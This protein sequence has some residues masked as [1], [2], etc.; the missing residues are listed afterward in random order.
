MLGCVMELLSPFT[1]M[2]SYLERG[3]RRVCLLAAVTAGHPPAALLLAGLSYNRRNVP[4]A[5]ESK[6]CLITQVCHHP[7]VSAAHAENAHFQYSTVSAPTTRF[8]GNS[9]EIFPNSRN[10]LL[11]KRSG[12]VYNHISPKAKANNIIIGRTWVDAFGD[13]HVNN[14]SNGVRC[15]LDFK[16]CG[17][18]SSNRYN[19]TGKADEHER[20]ARID[21]AVVPCSGVLAA[22]EA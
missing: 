18:F 20:A 17:W 19:F 1:P 14:A 9:L 3:F 11:L 15:L 16:P 7:P 8:L 12:E 5:M 10:R 4:P 2:L 21:V 22:I 13:F 6:H